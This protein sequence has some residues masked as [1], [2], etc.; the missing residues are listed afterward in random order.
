ME[1]IDLLYEE[2]RDCIY[3]RGLTGYETLGVLSRLSAEFNAATLVGD[4]LL[5]PGSC[6]TF[7][8]AG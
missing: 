2:L 4:G 8:P 5:A 3:R 1:P 6:F 7:P